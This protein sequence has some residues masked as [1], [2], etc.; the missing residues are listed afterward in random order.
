MLAHFS[1]RT[2]IMRLLFLLLLSTVCWAQESTCPAQQTPSDALG[3]FYVENSPLTSNVG[4]ESQLA[5]PLQRLEVNG[6]VLSSTNCELGIANV[7]VEVWYAGPPDDAG[8]FY[9]DDNYRGQVVTDACGR[10]SFVQT[11]PALYTARPILHDHLRVSRNDEELL[12][13]QMY[14]QGTEQGYVMDADS[15][16]MRVAQVATN[17]EGVRSVEFNMYIDIEGDAKCEGDE[18]P[19]PVGNQANEA[20]ENQA[21]GGITGTTSDGETRKVSVYLGSVLLVLWTFI[22][23]L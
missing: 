1:S 18:E 23:P 15:R 20:D 17:A 19:G 4:P 22:S 11:F 8:N 21:N 13:T 3:P 9:Q 10:Y 7:T 2:T 12:V 5:N 14:F 6:R 16:K